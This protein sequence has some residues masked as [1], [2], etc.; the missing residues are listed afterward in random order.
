M[1]DSEPEDGAWCR[2]G[3]GKSCPNPPRAACRK[4][5]SPGPMD[6][7]VFDDD[8]DDD[9]DDDGDDDGDD[10]DDED[11]GDDGQVH[12]GARRWW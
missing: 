3:R 10:N 9:D 4:G 1:T 11:D 8:D 6:G 7:D 5:R 2:R 12:L